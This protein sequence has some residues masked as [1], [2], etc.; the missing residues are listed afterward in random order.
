MKV[1]RI[2]NLEMDAAKHASSSMLV[3]LSKLCLSGQRDMYGPTVVRLRTPGTAGQEQERII[4][5]RCPSGPRGRPALMAATQLWSFWPFP[6]P[7]LLILLWIM[8]FRSIFSCFL[9]H[10]ST[11]ICLFFSVEGCW[12][13]VMIRRPERDSLNVV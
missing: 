9:I 6:V 8:I 5:D 1:P 4:T 10:C 7:R 11:N 3:H 13:E 2:E 12:V